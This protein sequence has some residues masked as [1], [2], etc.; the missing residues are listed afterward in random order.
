M[1]QYQSVRPGTSR[2][3]YRPGR[4]TRRPGTTPFRGYRGGVGQLAGRRLDPKPSTGSQRRT[5]YRPIKDLALL[6]RAQ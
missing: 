2:Y 3:W 1:T 6:P 5:W 4:P